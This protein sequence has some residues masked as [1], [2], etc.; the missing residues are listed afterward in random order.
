M[1]KYLI[2]F[3]K[4]DIINYKLINNMKM[5]GYCF[6]NNSNFSAETTDE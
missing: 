6:L 1:N 4:D 3:D 2:Y 5:V